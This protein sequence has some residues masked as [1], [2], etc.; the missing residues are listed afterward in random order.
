[1]ENNTISMAAINGQGLKEIAIG[2]GAGIVTCIGVKVAAKLV[3]IGVEKVKAVIEEK[4]ASKVQPAKT[5]A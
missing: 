3:K 5:N 2:Y 4:A 1:M